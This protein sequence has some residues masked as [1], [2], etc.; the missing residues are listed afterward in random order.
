[1]NKALALHGQGKFD[2]AIVEYQQI[3]RRHPGDQTVAAN[4]ASA[5]IRTGKFDDGLAL[6]E[7]LTSR[8]DQQPELWFNYANALQRAGQLAKSQ[9]TFERT[10]QVAPKFFPAA[11]NLANLVRDI[12]ERRDGC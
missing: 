12:G 10:L 7:E 11:L 3:R 1:M 8:S 5:L 2:E 9:Q 6:Y 4:L